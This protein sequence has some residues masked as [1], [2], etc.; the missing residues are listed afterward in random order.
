VLHDVLRELSAAP[1]PVY[2]EL[3]GVDFDV[4]FCIARDYPRLSFVFAPAG[5]QALELNHRVT[6]LPNVSIAMARTLY[7]VGQVE[8]ACRS[9]GAARILYASDLPQQHPGRPIG[10]IEDAEVSETDRDMILGGSA[11]GL[12]RK[13]GVTVPDVAEHPCWNSPPP[14][15]IMDTHGHI[16]SDWRRP[17]FDS[18]P[19]AVLRFLDRAGADVI[20]VSDTEGVFGDVVAGNRRTAIHMKSYPNRIRGYAVVNPWMGDACLE[21]IRRCHALGFSGLKPY[22]GTFGH[23]LS[24]PVMDPVWDLAEELRWPVLCHSDAADLRLVLEKRP[25]TRMLA[26]HMS[27]QYAEKAQ[28]AREFPN[29]VLEISGAG[30]GPEDILRAVEIA[31]ERKLVFGS[32]LNT[33]SLGF[34]LRPLLCSGLPESTLRA[35]LRENPLRFFA[36]CA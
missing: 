4:G 21:E 23:K 27:S 25:G 2:R 36:S 29:V 5:F 17:D 14:C 33:H 8:T 24:D 10:V 22:P 35:I 15:R 19:E 13:H 12:L 32:D 18:S 6:G 1:L 16:G 20:Y 34:T 31:G 3:A 7:S 11:L 30:A 26:A 9:M 28:L